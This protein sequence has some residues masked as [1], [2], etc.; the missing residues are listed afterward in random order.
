MS[1]Y[2]THPEYERG[3]ADGVSQATGK[4]KPVSPLA[5]IIEAARAYVEDLR[6]GLEDGTYEEGDPA[7]IEKA[8][9]EVSHAAGI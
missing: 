7:A 9:A 5:I 1:Q 3:F 8:I 4:P 2:G 6:S